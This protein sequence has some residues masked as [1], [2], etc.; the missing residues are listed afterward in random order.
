MAF[1]QLLKQSTAHEHVNTY[2]YFYRVENN[3][4]VHRILRTQNSLS[5]Q[6]TV[7]NVYL[8]T[9]KDMFNVRGNTLYKDSDPVAIKAIAFPS[10]GDPASTYV[11]FMKAAHGTARVGGNGVCF[12]LHGL[13]PDGSSIDPN[14]VKRA[15]FLAKELK[16]RHMGGIMRV[17]G[18]EFSGDYATRERAA[19]THLTW[20]PHAA[21]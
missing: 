6:A 2:V 10:L 19:R 8:S 3:R 16:D 1:I 17:F 9:N 18:P 5:W 12:T 15:K 21:R 4:S 14:A 11:D 13:S 20:T 7:S